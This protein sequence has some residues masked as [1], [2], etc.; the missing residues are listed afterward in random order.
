MTHDETE[1]SNDIHDFTT[2]VYM[3]LRRESYKWLDSSIESDLDM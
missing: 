3:I 2:V 1:L